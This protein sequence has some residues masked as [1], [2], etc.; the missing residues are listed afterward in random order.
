MKFISSKDLRQKSGEVWEKVKEED[1]IIT[2]NGKPIAILTS[3]DE[4]IEQQ[5]STIRRAKAEVS[6]FNMRKNAL[7]NNLDGLSEAAIEAEVK[8]YRQE[9]SR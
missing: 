5:L 4:D 7:Q 6:V 1:L 8:S 2:S 9:S 3:A